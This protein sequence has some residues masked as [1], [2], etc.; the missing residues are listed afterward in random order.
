MQKNWHNGY[1]MQE[2]IL[3]SL[4]LNLD[5]HEKQEERSSLYAAILIPSALYEFPLKD[6]INLYF[7]NEKEY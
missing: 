5:K 1:D 7:K 3:N 2:V 4:R 6:Y